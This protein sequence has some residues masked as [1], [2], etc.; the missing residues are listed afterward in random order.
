METPGSNPGATN[1]FFKKFVKTTFYPEKASKKYNLA[2][3]LFPVK[4]RGN[5]EKNRYQTSTNLPKSTPVSF[6]FPASFRVTVAAPPF[7]IFENKI[8]YPTF[9][10][11][12]IWQSMRGSSSNSSSNRRRRV[13]TSALVSKSLPFFPLS[14]LVRSRWEIFRTVKGG[15]RQAF[16]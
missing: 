15:I 5:L 3:G 8:S 14:L 4:K 9:C 1:L 16:F 6:F 7:P 13:M 11:V 12:F 2:L 10:T